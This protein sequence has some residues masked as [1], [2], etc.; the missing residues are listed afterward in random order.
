MSAG[1][2]SRGRLPF[3]VDVFFF[4][5]G[6]FILLFIMAL[7]PF[8]V[9]EKVRRERRL[10]RLYRR[11]RLDWNRQKQMMFRKGT[12]IAEWHLEG[13][14]RLWWLPTHIR[15]RHPDCPLASAGVLEPS[16]DFEERFHL[17]R[18]EKVKKWWESHVH[19]FCDDVHLVSFPFMH[20]TPQLSAA[21]SVVVV[22]DGLTYPFYH[23]ELPETI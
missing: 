13:I 15:T 2:K 19:E 10:R 14:A 4:F 1:N 6:P 9:A 11:R 16:F 20:R 7:I 5:A 18:D 8:G 22:D 17:L 12:I 3:W 21:T 23:W